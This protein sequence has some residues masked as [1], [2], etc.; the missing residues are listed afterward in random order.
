[1]DKNGIEGGRFERLEHHVYGGAKLGV[2]LLVKFESIL[3]DESRALMQATNIIGG[4]LPK[5]DIV[6][7]LGDVLE[8]VESVQHDLQAVM[9]EDPYGA[10]SV[11]VEPERVRITSRTET[12]LVENDLFQQ[13]LKEWIGFSK[14]EY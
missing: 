11:T 8:T 7:A 10:G 5:D 6:T 4:H 9:F 1:M 12:W 3:D 2:P 13:H 14:V